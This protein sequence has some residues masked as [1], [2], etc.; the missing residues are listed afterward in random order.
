MT[1]STGSD[2]FWF[3]RYLERDDSTTRLLRAVMDSVNDLR[4]ERG[5]APRTALAVLLGAV[6]D[7]TTTFPGFPELDLRDREAVQTERF[8]L[9]GGRGRPGSLAQ[10]CTALTHPTRTLRYLVTDDIWPVIARMRSRL[11]A[12]DP[13]SSVPLEQGLSEIIDSCLTLSGAAA[14]AMPRNLGWDLT[15]RKSTRLNSSHVA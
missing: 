11:S 8:G 4:S 12:L 10:S 1:R 3:G 7:V 9:L 5:P 13:G 6:T 14:D 2:L 15:D